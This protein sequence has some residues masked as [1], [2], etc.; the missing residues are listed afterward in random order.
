MTVQDL[1]LECLCQHPGST[2]RILEDG[3]HADT[4]IA[5]MQPVNEDY[6]TESPL[7]AFIESEKVKRYTQITKIQ[8]KLNSILVKYSTTSYSYCI[9]E[10][11]D[12]LHQ[13]K[14]NIL[15]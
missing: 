5:A 15:D 6:V 12:T 2:A 14:N 9:A 11:I 1:L 7:K 8:R 3:L 4:Y 13:V 10:C